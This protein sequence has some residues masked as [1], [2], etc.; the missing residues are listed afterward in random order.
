M[1]NRT[2]FLAITALCASMLVASP[3][4]ARKPVRTALTST[5]ADDNATGRAMLR[6]KSAS[7]GKFEIVA[8]HL[9]PDATYEV[10]VGGVRVADLVTN[11]GGN[12]KVRFRTRPRGTK[13][14]PLGFDPRDTTLTVRSAAGD[15][16]LATTFPDDDPTDDADVACCLPDDSGTEC[17]DRTADECAAQGGTVVAGATSC[18]PNPCAGATPVD[19][20]GDIVCCLPDDSGA[21]CEDRT[22][23]A[24]LA[25]GGTVVNATSCT[26]NPCAPVPPAGGDVVCC[27]ADRGGDGLNECEDLSADACTAAGGVVSDATSCMPDPCNTGT[28]PADEIACCVPSVTDGFDCESRTAD[29]CTAA[30]GSPAATGTCMP[31]PCGGTSG[32]GKGGSGSGSGGGGADDPAGHA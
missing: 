26:P 17:E 32:S 31:D 21:E 14:L 15:D 25:A 4:L 22:Q 6:L 23:D 9:D 10:I 27:L 1:R 5:G 13:D 7:E 20:D 12:G 30:G 8:R 28:P 24:C 2:Q 16:V 29:A 18:L 11:G 3:A 19:D